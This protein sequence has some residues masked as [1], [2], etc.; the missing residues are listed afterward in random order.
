MEQEGA[1]QPQDAAFAGR[2]PWAQR[3]KTPLSRFLQAEAS[4][5]AVLVAATLAALMWANVDHHSYETFWSTQLSVH[6]GDAVV[7]L[8]LRRWVN[9]GLMTFFFF[10]VGLEARREFDLGELRE[11]RRVALPIMAGGGGMGAAVGLFLAGNARS[12]GARGG[13]GAVAADPAVAPGMLAPPSP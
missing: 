3:L 6:L 5:A 4:G 1:A 12:G 10:V 2:T 13:G 11:R 9:S 8:D 7:S